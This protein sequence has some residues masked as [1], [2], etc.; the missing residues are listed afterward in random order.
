MNDALLKMDDISAA[1]SGFGDRK[2]DIFKH[3]VSL[4]NL[5]RLGKADSLFW[6]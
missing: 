4:E 5:F 6:V 2:A 1:K 3:L